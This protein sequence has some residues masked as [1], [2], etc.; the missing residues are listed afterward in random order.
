M[1]YYQ[2]TTTSI[3]DHSCEGAVSFSQADGPILSP[4][5]AAL[6]R[7]EAPSSSPVSSFQDQDGTQLLCLKLGKPWLLTW[8]MAVSTMQRLGI[9][10]R[11]DGMVANAMILVPCCPDAKQLP[12]IINHKFANP[13]K[14]DSQLLDALKDLW[15]QA[16]AQYPHC[17]QWFLQL[18]AQPENE[19]PT[20]LLEAAFTRAEVALQQAQDNL[21][22]RYGIHAARRASSLPDLDVWAAAG[23]DA[24]L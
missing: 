10:L 13:T 19:D 2:E 16:K 22:K 8:A 4:L 21:K 14:L 9:Q 17:N 15:N 23:G 7:R 3:G 18:R 5:P 12:A 1:S 11:L 20:V 6:L 24:M